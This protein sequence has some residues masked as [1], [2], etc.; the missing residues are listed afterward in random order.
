MINPP[1]LIFARLERRGRIEEEEE[2]KNMTSSLSAHITSL[3]AQYEFLLLLFPPISDV[4]CPENS[5]PNKFARPRSIEGKWRSVTINLDAFVRTRRSNAR[6]KWIFISS[7]SRRSRVRVRETARA[8]RRRKAQKWGTIGSHRLRLWLNF[9]PLLIFWVIT[10]GSLVGSGVRDGA[11]LGLR[12]LGEGRKEEGRRER[13]RRGPL[14]LRMRFPRS[15]E[16]GG[17]GWHIKQKREEED[18]KNE[19]IFFVCR[20]S[21]IRESGRESNRSKGYVFFFLPPI[22]QKQLIPKASSPFIYSKKGFSFSSSSSITTAAAY[23]SLP[24]TQPTLQHPPKG[25]R[26]QCHHHLLLLFLPAAKPAGHRTESVV[27]LVVVVVG[28]SLSPARYLTEV[29][30]KKTVLETETELPD[31]YFFYIMA[32]LFTFSNTVFFSVLGSTKAPP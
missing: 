4:D 13:E 21:Y 20:I 3:C 7:F 22:R 14:D 17:G 1:D 25:R 18:E 6:E 15:G 29:H 10:P 28:V 23:S 9:L 19:Q 16:G 12:R 27:L 32:T 30:S 2:E 5:P 11:C 26:R 8:G 24:P 31:I